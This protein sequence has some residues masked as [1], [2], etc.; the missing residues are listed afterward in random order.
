MWRGYVVDQITQEKKKYISMVRFTLSSVVYDIFFF[1]IHIVVP[2]GCRR[3][4][5]GYF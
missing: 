1:I 5:L 4:H 3:V 2:V